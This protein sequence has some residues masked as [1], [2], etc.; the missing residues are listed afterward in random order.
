MASVIERKGTYYIRISAGRDGEGSQVRPHDM[1]KPD[2][3]M[4]K[5]QIDKEIRKR[6][7][8]LEE[9]V[10]S[11]RL[12]E[13][14]IRF[15]IYAEKWIEYVEKRL[16]PKT[17]QRY[18]ELLQRINKAIGNVR[19][20]KLQPNHLIAFYAE[21]EE[22]GIRKDVRY[23]ATRGFLDAVSTSG[24]KAP[25][26]ARKAALS[27]S[28]VRIV[29]QEG[30]V[31][32]STA[33]KLSEALGL[34]SGDAFQKVGREQLSRRTILHY[35]R[36]IS[37]MLTTAVEWQII[38]S[39][40]ADRVRAP[41][42]QKTD[43]VFMDDTQARKLVELLQ[44]E[45]PEFRTMAILIIYLG[46]RRGELLGLKWSDIDFNKQVVQVVRAIQYIPGRGIFEKPPKSRSSVRVLKMSAAAVHLLLEHQKWQ[47]EQRRTCE[48][49]MWQEH[50]LVFCRWNG[51]YF[52][53][54]D[55]TRWFSGFL[56]KH[57]LPHGNIHG[58]RHTNASLMIAA[59]T[60]LTTVSKRLGHAQTS[61]TAIYAHA[62]RSADAAAAEALGD[63]LAPQKP[64]RK[65]RQKKTTT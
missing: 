37:S 1:F 22:C 49:G 33:T 65:S 61:T 54:D 46:F 45:P 2:P 6:I 29:L 32:K 64:R 52:N 60:N 15:S 42:V 19:L 48:E 27:E 43:P 55:L 18:K 44:T 47:L 57:G 28:T 50:D 16:E 31:Y 51:S 41:R 36:L 23:R 34:R 13:S 17:I 63:L 11:G 8:A 53:P 14:S 7:V 24:M 9:K 62:I 38:P 26:L 12:F 4:T 5:T 40:P 10:R 56:R 3:G 25:A 20:D 35:H 58:L 39:N 21:L 59:G 30:A